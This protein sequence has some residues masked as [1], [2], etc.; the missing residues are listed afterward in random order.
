MLQN[1]AFINVTLIYLCCWLSINFITNNFFLYIK[2]VMN[3][4]DHFGYLLLVIQGTAAAFLPLWN[5]VRLDS[6]VIVFTNHSYASSLLLAI[7]LARRRRTTL[8]CHFGL[9]YK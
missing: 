7:W 6:L 5:I 4:E 9:L 1:T 8:G 3:L 2:Y